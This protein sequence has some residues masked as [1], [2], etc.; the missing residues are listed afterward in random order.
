MKAFDSTKDI[1]MYGFMRSPRDTKIV[2]IQVP[3]GKD[4]I[5]RNHAQNGWLQSYFPGARLLQ[6]QWYPIKLDHVSKLA[7]MKPG[8]QEMLDDIHER[9]SK[10]NGVVAHKLRPLGRPQEHKH[11][12]SVV[13]YLQSPEDVHKLFKAREVT[14]G[15]M[16]VIPKEFVRRPTPVRCFN[17][18]RLGHGKRDCQHLARCERCS[19]EGHSLEDCIEPSPRCANCKHPHLASDHGCPAFRDE[20]AKLLARNN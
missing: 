4:V 13:A 10:K 18:Q 15:D 6:E 9:F 12:F 19:K 3:K 14:I 8:T 11:M 5:L 1:T 17:C 20:K 2:R 7:S 16:T